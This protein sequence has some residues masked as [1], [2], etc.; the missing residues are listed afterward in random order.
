MESGRSLLGYFI[1]WLQYLLYLL[2]SIWLTFKL[3]RVQEAMVRAQ[4]GILAKLTDMESRM[5][6]KSAGE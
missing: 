1:S 2:V 3:I 4:E 5:A 6:R